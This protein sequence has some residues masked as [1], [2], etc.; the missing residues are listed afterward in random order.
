M[1]KYLLL[2]AGL[3][4]ACNV[5]AGIITTTVGS[6]DG[7]SYSGSDYTYDL[8]DFTFDLNGESIISA[9][10]AGV[11]GETEIYSGS[12]AH[13][14]LYVDGI[15]VADTHDPALSCNPYNCVTN[16]T[17]DFTDFTAL[18]DG[19]LDFQAIQTSY[20]YLRLGETTLTIET[21]A[22][23]V[24]EPSSLAL[25]GLGLAGLG[26]SRRKQQA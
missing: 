5:S 3:L 20:T 22:A 24:P 1:K 10:L 6:F 18:L 26:L 14:E 25:L 15:Q 11:W 2:T 21:E 8:D 12:T 17:Y 7:L 19:V 4:L 9:S 16:W 13:A 23:A